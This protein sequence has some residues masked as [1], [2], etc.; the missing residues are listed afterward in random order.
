MRYVSRVSRL[1]FT[2][3][4]PSYEIPC[5]I[6]FSFG[7]PHHKAIKRIDI[8]WYSISL[9]PYMLITQNDEFIIV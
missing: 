3:G 8:R 7:S 9:K 6:L 1:D 2:S 5:F 4:R